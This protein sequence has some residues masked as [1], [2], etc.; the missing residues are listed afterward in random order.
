MS[1]QFLCRETK[2][3]Y[4]FNSAVHACIGYHYGNSMSQGLI[5]VG[6]LR[7]LRNRFGPAMNNDDHFCNR[8]YRVNGMKDEQGLW[9]E[10][11]SGR[12]ISFHHFPEFKGVIF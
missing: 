1:K 4:D 11:P 8:Y 2:Y 7:C 10:Y 12:R 3:E 6:R 9:R 5:P